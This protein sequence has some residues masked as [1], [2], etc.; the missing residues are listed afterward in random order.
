MP[1]LALLAGLFHRVPHPGQRNENSLRNIGIALFLLLVLH[2]AIMHLLEGMEWWTAVW[3]TLI[4]V[5]TVGYGDVSAKTMWGQVATI[6]LLVLPGIVMFSK[7]LSE[8]VESNAKRRERQLKGAWRWPMK[9]HILVFNAPQNVE[10][11]M[12]IVVSEFIKYPDF[13]HAPVQVVSTNFPNGLPTKLQD[14]NVLLYSG[15][16]NSE[17]TL[18]SVNVAM[19]KVIIVLAPDPENETSDAATFDLVHRIRDAGS[20]AYIV[21]ESIRDSNRRRIK[22]AGADATMRPIRAY[23]E[24][25]VRAVLAPGSELVIEEL[26]D[27]A[28]SEYR[29]VNT[30]A[31]S[32]PWSQ[33]MANCVGSDL[34]TPLAFIDDQGQIV[35]NPVGSVQAN[36]TGLILAVLDTATWSNDDLINALRA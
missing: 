3:L 22:S 13:Q 26:F 5:A 4:T 34:G 15:S 17:D 31:F 11:Y 23:P 35:I 33:V 36:F 21:A 30:P 16:G 1:L 20:K 2:V 6:A 14:M 12:S 25:A 8:I 29:R 27:S 24:I 7:L 28:G 32:M 9:D 18:D 19:A 10:S